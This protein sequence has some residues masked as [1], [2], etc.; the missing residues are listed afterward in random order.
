[1]GHNTPARI[2]AA[3]KT[4]L[5]DH[6][7]K[8][9]YALIRA[10]PSKSENPR[11]KVYSQL[12][13]GQANISPDYHASISQVYITTAE[14]ILDHSKSLLLL[15]CVEGAEFQQVP[16]LPSWVPDWSV[17]KD[18]GLRIT[19]YRDFHAAGDLPKQYVLSDHLNGKR[20]LTVKASQL[21][22]IVDT[23]EAK[24]ILKIHLYVSHLWNMI[25]KLEEDYSPVPGQSREEAVWRS[26]MTNRQEPTTSPNS[27]RYPASSEEF[28]PSFRAWLLWR[29]S[30]SPDEP[31]S[32]PSS[33]TSSSFIPTRA[34]FEDVRDR[35]SK[36]P[37]YLKELKHQA[38]LYDVHYAHAM[39]LRPYITSKGYF[40]IGTQCL[41]RGDTIWIVPGCRV[42][43]IFR[44]IEGSEHYRL[45]GG[46]YVHGFMNGEAL[47]RQDL[48]FSMVSLE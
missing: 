5:S 47:Q 13:L 34:E 45:V 48:E 18:L 38:S 46:C 28:E 6:D 11:D 16:D 4:W 10:R 1:M 24:K 12:G 7:E 27:T 17:R 29:F 8:L 42:P 3:R 25:S 14:Y 41:H 23:C 33:S 22:S 43:L 30:V 40:G 39:L 32:F 26:L 31:S 19:G 36:D 9:L 37:E 2:A 15:S 21:D 44:Q 35:C 20:I